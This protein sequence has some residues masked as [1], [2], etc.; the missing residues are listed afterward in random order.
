MKNLFLSLAFM[1]L[2]AFAF[3]NTSDNSIDLN[4]I[5][6]LIH[7]DNLE[8]TLEVPLSD[9]GF[10]VFYDDGTEGGSGSFQY[11]FECSSPSFWDDFF[12]MVG[13]V[14]PGW[15]SMIIKF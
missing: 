2:G 13:N 12:F 7:V 9:C 14:I 4:K 3:A 15:T 8:T 6:S 1:L 11:E 5:E 10:P